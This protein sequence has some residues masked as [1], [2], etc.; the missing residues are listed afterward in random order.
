[1]KRTIKNCENYA[2]IDDSSNQEQFAKFEA[3]MLFQAAQ[4][5]EKIFKKAVRQGCEEVA[6]DFIKKEFFNQ[7]KN[8]TE[9]KIENKKNSDQERENQEF[10]NF[11]SNTYHEYLTKK[12]NHSNDYNHQDHSSS[13][14]DHV[15]HL[16]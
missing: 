2:E 11:L 15:S 1:M 9:K 16:F 5:P 6:Q 8:Q 13:F 4:N 12:S 7:D 14:W 10:A 3:G